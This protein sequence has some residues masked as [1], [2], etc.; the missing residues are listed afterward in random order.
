MQENQIL[1]LLLRWF[2]TVFLVT[3][4]TSFR[5]SPVAKLYFY[6][7][8]MNAGKST[9]LLQSSYNYRE[10]GMQT[11][12]FKPQLDDRYGAN[13]ITSRIGLQDDAIE[14]DTNFNFFEYLIGQGLAH[15]VQCILIDE[16][17]FLTR[18]QVLQLSD[19]VDDAGIPVLA[20]G[21]RTDF[22]GDLFEG[23]Q[24]LLGLAEELIE[25]KTVCHCGRKATMNMRIDHNRKK[26]EHGPSVEIG[27]NDR[28]V[29]TCHKHFKLGDAGPIET[30][31]ATTIKETCNVKSN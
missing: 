11:L 26:V 14:F 4:P 5:G 2:E 29:A 24:H 9:T 8:A 22:K 10:R 21:L 13:K 27:G 6:Y 19:V 1:Y 15:K 3:I 18:N 30:P 12:L 7:S 31:V 16:A 20:Y 25:I 28:Y 17:Q 23:S